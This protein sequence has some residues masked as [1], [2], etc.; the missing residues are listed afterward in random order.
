LRRLDLA[1]RLE[2]ESGEDQSFKETE[3]IGREDARDERIKA[4]RGTVDGKHGAFVEKSVDAHKRAAFVEL[5]VL[6]ELV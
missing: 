2:E 1:R 6:A 4:A 3:A 5:A